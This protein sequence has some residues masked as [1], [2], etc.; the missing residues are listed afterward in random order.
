MEQVVVALRQAHPAWGGRKI[1][2]PLRELGHADVLPPST[3]TS[4]LHRHGLIHP[5]ASAL[6]TPLQ[7]FEHARPNELWQIDFKG[8]FAK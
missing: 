2:V 3:V 6:A 5:A 1:C 8:D 7:R 4:V